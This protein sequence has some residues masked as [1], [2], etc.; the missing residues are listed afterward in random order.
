[1]NNS[2]MYHADRTTHLKVVVIALVAAVLVASV[3]VTARISGG[4]APTEVVKAGQPVISA[5]APGATVR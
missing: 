1:M 2:S 4:V 5:T 3:S